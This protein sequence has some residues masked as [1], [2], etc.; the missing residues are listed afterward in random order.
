MG[1]VVFWVWTIQGY[2]N[3]NNKEE[4]S[5]FK[6]KVDVLGGNFRESNAFRIILG[7]LEDD[8]GRQRGRVDGLSKGGGFI[9]VIITVNKRIKKD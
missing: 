8:E 7:D 4:G 6:S 1:K 2:S 5:F 3:A 9:F